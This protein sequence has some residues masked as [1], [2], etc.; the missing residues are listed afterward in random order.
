MIRT[1]PKKRHSR[2]SIQGPVL[3][4]V[5]RRQ[6]RSTLYRED[7]PLDSEKGCEVRSVR[8]QDDERE[9]PPDPTD[10]SG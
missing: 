1:H 8:G 6:V 10:Y 4:T 2:P 7:R 9:E 3:Y 5:L